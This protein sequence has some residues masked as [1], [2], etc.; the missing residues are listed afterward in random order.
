MI[1]NLL[2]RLRLFNSPPVWIL[3]LFLPHTLHLVL[4]L[5]HTHSHGN[6]QHTS[7]APCLIFHEDSCFFM[8]I[9]QLHSFSGFL[10]GNHTLIQSQ[11]HTHTRTLSFS[12]VIL[13]VVAKMNWNTTL[14]KNSN[15]EE[16]G[17]HLTKRSLTAP[18]RWMVDENL[19]LWL[20]KRTPTS[21]RPLPSLVAD[22]FPAI[23]LTGSLTWCRR[24]LSH[25]IA[26]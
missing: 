18:K 17:P 8:L 3:T 1:Y 4:L 23:S 16:I 21:K 15:W 2:F 24:V 13:C 25:W 10:T 7:R 12:T 5:A 19:S 6:P 11:L 20:F 9:W 22:S 26:R 14:I